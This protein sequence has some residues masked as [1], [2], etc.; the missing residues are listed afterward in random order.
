MI[1]QLPSTL[2]EEVLFHQYG[3]II[4]KFKF[5]KDI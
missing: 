1:K 2:K 3:S 5:F 4:K